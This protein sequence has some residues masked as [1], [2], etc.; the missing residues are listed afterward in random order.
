VFVAEKFDTSF[1]SLEEL[2]ALIAGPT[3]FTIPV[4]ATPSYTHRHW[5]RMALRVATVVIGLAVIVA[6]CRY[7]ARDNEK[8]V[9]IVARGHV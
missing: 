4:I 8:L 7:V 5:R 1:H 3:L 6:G 2:R 9:R